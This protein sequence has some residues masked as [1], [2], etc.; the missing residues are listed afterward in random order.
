MASGPSQPPNP[1]SAVVSIVKFNAP[2]EKNNEMTKNCV[3]IDFVGF[4]G[5]REFELMFH[6]VMKSLNEDWKL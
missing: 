5:V 3:K 1:R 4:L 2:A 6:G